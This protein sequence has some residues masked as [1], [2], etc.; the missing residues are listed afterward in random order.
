M[1]SR[2]FASGRKVGAGATTCPW[3]PRRPA[4]LPI[5]LRDPSERHCQRDRAGRTLLEFGQRIGAL[6]G[7]GLG[8]RHADG[9]VE[10]AETDF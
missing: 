1:P 9:V 7:H 6:P 3:S 10:Y 8:D 2:R 5:L 4:R